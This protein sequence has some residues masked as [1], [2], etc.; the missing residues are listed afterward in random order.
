MSFNF[1][2][3]LGFCIFVCLQTNTLEAQTIEGKYVKAKDTFIIAQHP[4]FE[5]NYII[6]YPCLNGICLAIN[7]SKR[8][9]CIIDSTGKV[10][11]TGYSKGYKW[12]RTKNSFYLINDYDMLLIKK[13]K[14]SFVF[15][16]KEGK[17]FFLNS[18][19]DVDIFLEYD[20]KENS[21]KSDDN[22]KIIKIKNGEII[23]QTKN[24]QILMPEFTRN[25][26]KRTITEN[27]IYF[28]D[29]YSQ[30]IFVLTKQ[31][32][33]I[34]QDY[35]IVQI[36][37][38]DKLYLLKKINKGYLCTS[39]NDSQFVERHFEEFNLLETKTARYENRD[40][41][42]F[43]EKNKYGALVKLASSTY[44]ESS[45]YFMN[46]EY[47]S[48]YF[49]TYSPDKYSSE[50]S[51]LFGVIKDTIYLYDY[52]SNFKIFDI[53]K[54]AKYIYHRT[55]TKTG[56]VKYKLKK[57]QNTEDEYYKVSLLPNAAF[58]GTSL[59]EKKYINKNTRDTFGVTSM[60]LEAGLGWY[61]IEEDIGF[62][63]GTWSVYG[64]GIELEYEIP[65]Y[66]KSS[67]KD[68]TKENYRNLIL[69]ARVE[70]G[71][72]LNILFI[73]I[74]FHF[75]AGYSTNFNQH[76]F[77]PGIGI[78]LIRFQLGYEANINRKVLDNEG[79]YVRYICPLY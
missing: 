57:N 60:S 58:F 31:L 16:E 69:N 19:E 30:N 27:E 53:T 68:K 10:Y 12:T 52:E 18:I 35:P 73:P 1:N 4:G 5:S 50:K 78:S 63:F 54:S 24:I 9:R 25:L 36:F 2:I 8:T 32:D 26:E 64:G 17:Y 37:E 42:K 22:D 61:E 79:Y 49:R 62:L 33:T 11:E 45:T 71:V 15:I 70:L 67:F 7:K 44:T 23:S 65:F 6:D 72:G 3:V 34:K 40:F 38:S 20:S 56:E 46:A 39:K 47:D 28:K 76:F 41:F 59:F 14:D 29:Y 66:S 48:L 21:A 51:Y 77:R 75:H 74:S 13:I 43:K 55:Y